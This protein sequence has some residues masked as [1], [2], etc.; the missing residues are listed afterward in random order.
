M[1][2]NECLILFEMKQFMN[3]L[4]VCLYDFHLNV[5]LFDVHKHI[6]YCLGMHS[7]F[8]HKHVRLML[9]NHSRVLQLL[10]KLSLNTSIKI[11]NKHK[12]NMNSF[13]NK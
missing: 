11:H 7:L 6:F 10:N 8:V 9:T 13:I 3:R 5:W 1:N 2:K 12:P 4:N